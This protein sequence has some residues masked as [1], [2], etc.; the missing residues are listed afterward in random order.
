M[1]RAIEE[2]SGEAEERKQWRGWEEEREVEGGEGCGLE[3]GF[4]FPSLRGEWK[5]IDSEAE[6][7]ADRMAA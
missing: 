5:A 6:S 3:Y 4:G 2:K 1:E 7:K